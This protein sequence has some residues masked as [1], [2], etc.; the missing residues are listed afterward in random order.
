MNALNS[1]SY[2]DMYIFF[3]SKNTNFCPWLRASYTELNLRVKFLR[4]CFYFSKI[5]LCKLHNNKYK[6]ASTQITNTEFVFKGFL[7]F[8]LLRRKV[9]FINRKDNRD[10]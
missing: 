6:I 10:C 4:I 9:L 1:C 8:K 3:F 7:D 5:Q 2:F